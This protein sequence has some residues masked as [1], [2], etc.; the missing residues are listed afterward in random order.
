MTENRPEIHFDSLNLTPNR[1][2]V[3]MQRN[4]NSRVIIRR[5]RRRQQIDKIVQI[6]ALSGFLFSRARAFESWAVIGESFLQKVRVT[7][8]CEIALRGVPT[9]CRNDQPVWFA[10][11]TRESRIHFQQY[12]VSITL[13][14]L[15]RIYYTVSFTGCYWKTKIEIYF[16]VCGTVPVSGHTVHEKQAGFTVENQNFLTP[17]GDQLEFGSKQPLLDQQCWWPFD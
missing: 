2:P 15:H 16:D 3:R 4:T 1:A 12:T 5:W 13:Y 8:K 9:W 7:W 14:P 11:W 10:L 6:N 17:R